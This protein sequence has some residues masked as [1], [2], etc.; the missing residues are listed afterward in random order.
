[1]KKIE[2]SR[3]HQTRILIQLI[4]QRRRK[5]LSPLSS[6]QQVSSPL[7]HPPKDE[8]IHADNQLNNKPR[9][10]DAINNKINW[11]ICRHTNS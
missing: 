7:Y 9:N 3:T 11:I 4:Q 5:K 2:T 1:M 6:S 10:H 8:K